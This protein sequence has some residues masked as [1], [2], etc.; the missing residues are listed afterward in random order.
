VGAWLK[1]NGEAI[2]GAGRTPFG[3]ELGTVL[4]GPSDKRGQPPFAPQKEWRYTTKPGKLYVHFFQWPGSQFK[5]SGLSSRAAR[6]YL[7]ADPA[8]RPLQLAQAGSEL[9]VQLPPTA[10]DPLASVLCLELLP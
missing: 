7:L 10:P 4:P 8:R 5:L 2:Y 3:A 6:A 1:V 9:T